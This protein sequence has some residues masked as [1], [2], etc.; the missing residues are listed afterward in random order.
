MAPWLPE[1]A[2][3]C[4]MADRFYGTAD[5]I[6]LCQGLGWDYRLRL[7]GNLVVRDGGRTTKTGVLARS[8]TFALE[9]VQLT[10]KKATTSVANTQIQHPG[11]AGP[12]AA[13]HGACALLRRLD[14]PVGRPAPPGSRRKKHLSRQPKKVA[15]SKTSWFTRGLRR[16]TKLIQAALPLPPLWS[17]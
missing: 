14:R 8:R 2:P 3:A 7:K 16:I 4:L 10:A 11:P 5:L 17:T 13:R 6:S 9:N 15:R 1:G 12:L